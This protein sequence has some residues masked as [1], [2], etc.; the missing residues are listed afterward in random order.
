MKQYQIKQ[1]RKDLV[2]V[3]IVPD[4]HFKEDNKRQINSVLESILTDVTIQI[5]TSEGID[6]EENGK[7]RIVIS[8]VNK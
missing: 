3:T 5:K 2:T 8:E 4:N 6:R 1:E 7:Y